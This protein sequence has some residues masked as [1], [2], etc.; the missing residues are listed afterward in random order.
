[1]PH[2]KKQIKQSWDTHISHLTQFMPPLETYNGE[3]GKSA[4]DV[5]GPYYWCIHTS[6]Y[7]RLEKPTK[8]L[9]TQERLPLC[10]YILHIVPITL[11]IPTTDASQ[12]EKS[13]NGNIRR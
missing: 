7:S 1:M 12:L 5:P 13:N 6:A 8:S 10:T 2:G 3:I 11:R 9:V 4:Y